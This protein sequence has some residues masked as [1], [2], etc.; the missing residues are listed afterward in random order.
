M[1]M[2][3]YGAKLPGLC[4]VQRGRLRPPSDPPQKTSRWGPFEPNGFKGAAGT[5]SRVFKALRWPDEFIRC[6]SMA[7]GREDRCAV[8]LEDLQPTVQIAGMAFDGRVDQ[9]DMS[10][11]ES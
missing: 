1:L 2:L 10:E 5:R 9:P 7:R 11:Q 3:L 4:T 6:A 8:V